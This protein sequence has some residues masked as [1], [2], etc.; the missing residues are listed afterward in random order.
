METQEKKV[1]VKKETKQEIDNIFATLEKWKAKKD[2]VQKES[3]AEYEAKI[4]ELES[5]KKDLQLRYDEIE[6]ATEEKWNEIS[7]AVSKSSEDFKKG[8]SKL[9]EAIS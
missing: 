2:E 1:K 5:K 6:G 7:E 8:F 4:Q 9:Q 3:K